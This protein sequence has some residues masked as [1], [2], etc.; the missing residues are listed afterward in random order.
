MSS[1]GWRQRILHRLARRGE[2]GYAATVLAVGLASGLFIGAAAIAVDTGRWYAEQERLQS[3]ADAAATAGVPYLPYDM[4]SAKALAL[5][6]AARNGYDPATNPQVRV[7]V[8]QG[9][10]ASQLRVTISSR[11]RNAFGSAIGV[12]E[13]AVSRTAVA[14]YKGAAPMGSPCNTFGN[15]PDSGSGT[16]PR[17][18]GT[19]RDTSVANCSSF[20]M[21]WAGI[22]GPQT[23]KSNGDRYSNIKCSTGDTYA[24]T[25]NTND[26]TDAR[27]Y[28][29][30]VRV[31]E[32]AVGQPI[33][34]QLYD[35][36]YVNSGNY[37]CSSLPSKPSNNSGGGNTLR[38]NMNPYVT[39]DGRTRYS[40]SAGYGS[41]T[42]PFCNGDHRPSAASTSGM[43][44]MVTSFV[45][46]AQTD[47][48][49]PMKAAPIAGC[50]RQYRGTDTVPTA[51]MLRS[52]STGGSN[53]RY[54]DHL[55]Q[56]FHNWTTLCTFTPPRAGDYYLQVRSNVSF[57]GSIQANGSKD[58]MISTGNPAAT[59]ATGNMTK[60]SG[61]NTFSIRA[62]VPGFQKYVSV[63]GYERMPIFANAETSAAT[64]F[65]LIRV[66]PGAA[67][68]FASFNFFDVA[69]ADNASG[70]MTVLPPTDAEGSIKTNPFPGGC[71]T[72][73]G[74]YTDKT[75][76]S[77]CSVTIRQDSNNKKLHTISIPIPRDYDCA[78]ER[79][80]GCWYRVRVNLSGGVH[81]FTTW[82]ASITGDPVRII[83]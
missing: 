5:E 12:T 19:A 46:R 1:T 4:A 58:S 16:S 22:Q 26:E 75:T 61:N 63:S 76:V 10:V 36:A 57:G 80:D 25:G 48:Q 44:P 79:G 41:T 49:D 31:E 52:P 37:L 30:I 78:Y 21:L 39:D 65:H 53:S 59:A 73:G 3:A 2:G 7:D 15:E 35:P 27:G 69:D 68:Q 32:E 72:Q 50:N 40:R 38:D 82:E 13:A 20:P 29:W 77:N 51:E 83:E 11:V 74:M 66:L 55:A 6:V 71:T 34:V 60:S 28:F 70:T 24:C 45:L 42:A 14:D 81:D 54:N 17:P 56:L 18:E 67:G 23:D 47:T 9:E 43:D 64:T 8:S 33:Q 62:V